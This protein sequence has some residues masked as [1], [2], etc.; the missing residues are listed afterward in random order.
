MPRTKSQKRT[1]KI[2][3]FR[4]KLRDI[5]N[6]LSAVQLTID[7]PTCSHVDLRK[8]KAL[9][10]RRTTIER[11]KR[12]KDKVLTDQD[13]K[14][15]LEDVLL[16]ET[17]AVQLFGRIFSKMKDERKRLKQQQLLKEIIQQKETKNAT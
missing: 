7:L 1:A 10:L 14:F 12:M 9:N 6:N 13:L 11:I 17:K 16:L 15:F 8:K 5:D 2:R 4:Q 3:T